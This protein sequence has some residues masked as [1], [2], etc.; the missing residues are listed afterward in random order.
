MLVCSALSDWKVIKEE[1]NTFDKEFKKGKKIKRKIKIRSC[2][3]SDNNY[4]YFGVGVSVDI[5]TPLQVL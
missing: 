5:M 4:V 3:G 2:E 1:E